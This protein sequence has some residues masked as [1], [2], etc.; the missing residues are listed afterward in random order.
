M[1][2]N[3]DVHKFSVVNVLGG[4]KNIEMTVLENLAGV[5]P[6]V[7]SHIFSLPAV[8]LVICFFTRSVYSKVYTNFKSS[9]NGKSFFCD[10]F[11]TFIYF[12]FTLK[13]HDDNFCIYIIV[14]CCRTICCL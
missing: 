11:S 5:M 7:S 13:L 6:L 3:A 8:D 9:K 1:G 2:F 14:C 4:S 10:L 12:T